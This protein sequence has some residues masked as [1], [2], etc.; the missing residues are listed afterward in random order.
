MDFG[1]VEYVI[2]C[3]GSGPVALRLTLV[4]Q[5][6]DAVLKRQGLSELR[7][8]RIVRLASEA[9]EQGCL[10]GYEDLAGLLLCSLATLKRDLAQ[11]R[12]QGVEVPLRVRKKNGNENPGGTAC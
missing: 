4:G 8:R 10:L 6:D 2:E 12:R 9:R 1:K 5:N 7:R 11:L 3:N